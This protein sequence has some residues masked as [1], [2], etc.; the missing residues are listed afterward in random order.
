[1]GAI[2]VVVHNILHLRLK[3]LLVNQIKVNVVFSGDL[4]PDIALN[5]VNEA[6][7]IDLV[8]LFPGPG[9]VNFVI[10]LFEEQDLRGRPNDQ[11]FSVD[12]NHLIQVFVY[13]LLKSEI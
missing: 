8:V 12:Q 4:D 2:H 1:M 13:H 7:N 9:L 11:C 3:R 6:P 10:D 5:E